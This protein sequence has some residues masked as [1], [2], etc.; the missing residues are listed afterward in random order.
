VVDTSNDDQMGH[1]DD[2][3]MAG[4][5]TLPSVQLHVMVRSCIAGVDMLKLA[6]AETNTTEASAVA[7][8]L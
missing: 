4:T 3:M 6:A 8:T 1:A 2:T 7:C 5:D